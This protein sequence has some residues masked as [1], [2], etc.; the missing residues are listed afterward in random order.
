MYKVTKSISTGLYYLHANGIDPNTTKSTNLVAVRASFSNIRLSE[1]FYMRINPQ[2]YYL[3]M[4]GSD[5]FY[6][7]STLA[8]AMKNFPLSV[9]GLINQPIKTNISAGN[10]FLWN[11]SLVYAFNKE[12]TESG[13]NVLMKNK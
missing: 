7:N 1:K 6:F 8:I 2:V 4:D 13:N 11:V 12:Y 5:G 9:S 3:N 10:E